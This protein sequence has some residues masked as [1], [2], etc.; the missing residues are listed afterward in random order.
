MKRFSPPED[1]RF[2]H[3]QMRH[4]HRSGRPASSWQQWVD[5]SSSPEKNRRK[6]VRITLVLLALAAVALVVT[7]LVHGRPA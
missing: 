5:A 3:A 2:F 4:Y 1:R 6:I 7:L